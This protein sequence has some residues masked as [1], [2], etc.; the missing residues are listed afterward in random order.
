MG[1]LQYDINLLDILVEVISVCYKCQ[2]VK[3]VG[4]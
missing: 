2:G 1:F 3:S 4:E